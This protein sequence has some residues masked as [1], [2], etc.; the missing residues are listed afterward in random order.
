LP[1]HW[2]LGSFFSQICYYLSLKLDGCN[3]KLKL[4]A[5]IKPQNLDSME[6]IS[7]H[8]EICKEIALFNKFCDFHLL[9]D[10][11]IYSSQLAFMLFISFFT[12]I[13]DFPKFTF[14]SFSLFIFC[15]F[16]IY[17]IASIF[18]ISYTLALPI[19]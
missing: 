9:I 17:G 3:R 7:E 14:P 16:A 10:A 8:N 2:V 1:N 12:N 11:I 19:L 6:I 13:V 18:N 5:T 4:Y 15:F